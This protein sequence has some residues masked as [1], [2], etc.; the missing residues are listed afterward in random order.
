MKIF[1]NGPPCELFNWVDG[2]QCF[3]DLI[4]MIA[5]QFIT[6]MVL[7]LSDKVENITGV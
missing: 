2:P 5:N 7:V 1:C 4:L 6:L 3:V